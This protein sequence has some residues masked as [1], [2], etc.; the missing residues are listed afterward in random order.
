MFRKCVSYLHRYAFT[1]HYLQHKNRNATRGYK[2]TL[3]LKWKIMKGN[4]FV[5]QGKLRAEKSRDGS[6]VRKA[7]FG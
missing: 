3:S 5:G 2:A 7:R 1:M 6:C 4:G